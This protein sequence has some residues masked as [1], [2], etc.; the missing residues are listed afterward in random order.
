MPRI[1]ASTSTSRGITRCK[2]HSV[3]RALEAGGGL[4][5]VRCIRREV[6]MRAR[7]NSYKPITILFVALVVMTWLC[8]LLWGQS[9]YGRFLGHD[10]MGAV[11]PEDFPLFAVIFVAGWTLMIA[12]MMLPTSLHPG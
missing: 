5:A 7:V 2:A 6:T 8:L 1:M 10:G 12:A 9:P 3:S 4:S 11:R